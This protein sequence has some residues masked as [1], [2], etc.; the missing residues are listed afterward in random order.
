MG[1]IDQGDLV[2]LDQERVVGRAVFDFKLNVETVAIPVE[3][4][5]RDRMGRDHFG[6]DGELRRSRNSNHN[7][8]GIDITLLWW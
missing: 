7:H 4:A 3:G 2:A 1:G 6:L 5:D 8:S